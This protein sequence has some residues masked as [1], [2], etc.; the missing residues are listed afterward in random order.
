[1]SEWWALLRRLRLDDVLMALFLTILLGA[2]VFPQARLPVFA[3][4][5]A[6]LQSL[7][8]IIHEAGHF[9]LTPLGT[10]PGVLGGT[11]AQIAFP[12][13][14]LGSALWNQRRKAAAFFLFWIGESLIRVAPYMAD[15]RARTLDLFS[16]LMLFG[17][18]N[19]LHDWNYIL[20]RLGLLW[21]DQYLAA[22]VYGLAVMLMLAAVASPFILPKRHRR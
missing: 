1:M 16:P 12:A 14:C 6:A 2:V 19:A 5:A 20:G 18:K 15:A 13:L 4:I 17:S 10:F 8:F 21:A 9:L 22:L 3:L 11:L 7:D